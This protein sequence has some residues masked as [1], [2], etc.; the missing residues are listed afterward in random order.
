MQHEQ[1][2]HYFGLTVAPAAFVSLE[3]EAPPRI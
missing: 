1:Q 3:V 2:A